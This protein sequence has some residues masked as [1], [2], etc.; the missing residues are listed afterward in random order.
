MDSDIFS[1]LNRNRLFYVACRVAFLRVFDSLLDEF[2]SHSSSS[3]RPGFLERI[4]MFVGTAPQVQI[5]LLLQTWQTLRSETPRP[6][7]IEEQVICFGIT[8]ELA[9]TGVSDDKRMIHRAARGPVRVDAGDIVW[10][11]SRV[12]ML[13]ILLPFA[14]QAAV[15]QVE[16]GIAADDLIPVRTAGGVDEHTFTGLLNLLGNWTVNKSLF[17][18]A[19]GLLDSTEIEMLRAFF[20][21][22]PHLLTTPVT[23]P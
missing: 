6:L 21:E 23:L 3:R 4:P 2:I 17:A 13:Q 11:A 20:A 10:L 12:R 5:E 7:T 22:H 19:E 15:L 8:S 9:H 1:E 14:P 16:S 18:N